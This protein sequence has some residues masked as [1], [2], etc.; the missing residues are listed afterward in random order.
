MNKNKRKNNKRT[1]M[2]PSHLIRL[3]H[4]WKELHPF[5]LNL[6]RQGKEYTSSTLFQLGRMKYGGSHFPFKNPRQ[7]AAICRILR[8]RGYLQG[9]KQSNA[10]ITLWKKTKK[11]KYEYTKWK[12]P[13]RKK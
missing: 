9:K 8:K 7:V 12:N 11:Q 4:K 13:R 5:V 3:T 10:N 2:K 1:L 6:M